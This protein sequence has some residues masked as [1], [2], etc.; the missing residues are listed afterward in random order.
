[1]QSRARNIGWRIDHFAVHKK[2][3]DR[4]VAADIL[5]DVLGSDHCPVT[6]TMD[7]G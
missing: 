7:L 6:V 5:N 3:R 1:M 2:D 4:L